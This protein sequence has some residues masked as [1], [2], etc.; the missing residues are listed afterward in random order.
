MFLGS[1]ESVGRWHRTAAIMPVTRRN[2]P[3]SASDLEPISSTGAIIGGIFDQSVLLPWLKLVD[4]RWQ[5]TCGYTREAQRLL[6]TMAAWLEVL[7][8]I[9]FHC[10]LGNY[11]FST[12]STASS[13]TEC[14][15][16]LSKTFGITFPRP[17]A[18]DNSRV[19]WRVDNRVRSGQ[20]ARAKRRQVRNMYLSN[21][22]R[23][24]TSLAS[25]SSRFA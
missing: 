6:A 12:F 16:L 3:K 13:R 11:G 18:L 25:H 5:V 7:A 10:Q 15:F 9:V 21:K 14:V 24:M 19:W 22:I 2:E 23:L 20:A 17:R 8:S 1:L 4:Q